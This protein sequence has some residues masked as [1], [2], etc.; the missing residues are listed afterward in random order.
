ML[1]VI[2]AHNPP[3]DFHARR[4]CVHAFYGRAHVSNLTLSSV[5]NDWP[6]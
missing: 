4:E 1:M 5:T 2:V 3:G 6:P